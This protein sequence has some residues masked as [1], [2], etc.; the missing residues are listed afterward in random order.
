L[1]DLSLCY[2]DKTNKETAMAQHKADQI[3]ISEIAKKLPINTKFSRNDFMLFIGMLN[4]KTA[5]IRLNVLV[6]DKYLSSELAAARIHSYTMSVQQREG[7]IK[8]CRSNKNKTGK[9]KKEKLSL[10]DSGFT[11]ALDK[12]VFS[13]A[14]I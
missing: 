5:N 12:L 8:R 1:H 10:K 6:K 11:N 4:A 2:V 13:T 3:L 9:R 7:M 14:W